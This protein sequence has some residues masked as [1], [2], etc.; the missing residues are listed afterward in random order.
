MIEPNYDDIL[1]I[2]ISYYGN[3]KAAY[4]FTAEEYARQYFKLNKHSVLDDV[5]G[6]KSTT[7]DAF[8]AT[9]EWIESDDVWIEDE[10][11]NKVEGLKI[12]GKNLKKY[13]EPYYR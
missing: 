8:K 3:T 9:L 2:K 5:S 13:C 1:R 4:Q 7:S 6:S 10:Q 11:G 12:N